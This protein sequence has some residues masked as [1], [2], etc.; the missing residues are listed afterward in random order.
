MVKRGFESMK[1]YISTLNKDLGSQSTELIDF[2]MKQIEGRS[3]TGKE[4]MFQAIECMFHKALQ[5]IDAK[6]VPLLLT[7]LQTQALRKNVK[8]QC[9]ALNCITGICQKWNQKLEI[10]DYFNTKI[11][12][13]L[14]KDIVLTISDKDTSQDKFEKQT[15]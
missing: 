5:C 13:I 3:W 1:M 6:K 12:P 11:A 2:I 4:I 7:F 9:G 15:E 10:V 14:L 8:F